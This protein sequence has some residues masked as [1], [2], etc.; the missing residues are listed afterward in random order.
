MDCASARVR[1]E[2]R[3]RGRVHVLSCGKVEHRTDPRALCEWNVEARGEAREIEAVRGSRVVPGLL[4]EMKARRFDPEAVAEP[5]VEAAG[6]REVVG[7][8]DAETCRGRRAADVRL[9]A[10]LLQ[11]PR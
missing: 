1:I 6:G 8:L 2:G 5:R 4:V 10:V 7:E 11:V 9:L 3:L